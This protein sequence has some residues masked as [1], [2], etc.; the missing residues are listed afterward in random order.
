[1]MKQKYNL[2]CSPAVRPLMPFSLHLFLFPTASPPTKNPS[3][4]G[5]QVSGSLQLIML[6]AIVIAIHYRR[7]N[8]LRG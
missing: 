3:Y 6:R 8:R 2:P 5:I 1:M 7:L 4:S